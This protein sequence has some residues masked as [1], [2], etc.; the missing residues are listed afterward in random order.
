MSRVREGLVQRFGVGEGRLIQ[1]NLW[2]SHPGGDSRGSRLSRERRRV[3]RPGA[4]C[5][6]L[7]RPPPGQGRRRAGRGPAAIPC[8]AGSAGRGERSHGGIVT[9]PGT[10]GI[11]SR[12]GGVEMSREGSECPGLSRD[13]R[14]RESRPRSSS[15]E[16]SEGEVASRSEVG[17]A[18]RLSQGE[19]REA[20]RR[21]SPVRPPHRSPSGQVPKRSRSVDR[22]PEGT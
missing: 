16:R 5:G 11:K 8:G 4:G 20:R 9:P 2:K 14:S 22:C 1:P 7:G 10:A 18:A 17:G 13:D 12:G 15:P 19:A 6:G 21:Q 3:F